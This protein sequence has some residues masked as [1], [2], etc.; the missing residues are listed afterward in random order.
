LR[1]RRSPF[2][3]RRSSDL[4]GLI[5]VAYSLCGVE[6]AAMRGLYGR[7]WPRPEQFRA[8][9]DRE[10]PKTRWRLDLMVALAAMIPTLAVAV[11]LL[12]DRKSTR[13]NSSHV[14]IS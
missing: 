12:T 7:L 14:K 9:A 8:T 13:L 4:S 5:A 6:Y 1:G 11:L 3:T 2:P 10:L